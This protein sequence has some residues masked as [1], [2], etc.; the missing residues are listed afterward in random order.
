MNLMLRRPEIEGIGLL[1]VDWI[2]V[3]SVDGNPEK[4]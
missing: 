1:H 3:D 4:I 2:R